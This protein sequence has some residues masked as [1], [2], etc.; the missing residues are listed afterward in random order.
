M[1]RVLEQAPTHFSWH[2]VIVDP[3]TH[4]VYAADF[5]KIVVYKTTNPSAPVGS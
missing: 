1:Y 2:F 3:T 4:G 5:E